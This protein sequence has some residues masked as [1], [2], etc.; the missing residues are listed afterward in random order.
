MDRVHY[1]LFTLGL[2]ACVREAEQTAEPNAPASSA[3]EVA[4]AA[5]SEDA[6]LTNRVWVRDVGAG[7][8]PGG[9]LVFLDDGTLIQ[10]S[11]WETYRL[12]QWTKS[13]E[14]VSWTEDAMEVSADVV[15]LDDSELTLRLNLPA[16]AEEQK[17]RAAETPFV[18][19]DMPR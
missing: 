12:S 15:S 11:C 3:L 18:C 14:Q 4:P 7:E 19:P 2:A 5:S 10:D 16:G 9:M 17:F 13:G 8:I 1:L 6:P